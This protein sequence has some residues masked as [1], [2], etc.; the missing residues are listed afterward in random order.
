[1]LTENVTGYKNHLAKVLARRPYN[2]IALVQTLNNA[3][4]INQAKVLGDLTSKLGAI[5]KCLMFYR[6]A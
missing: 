4:S 5:E 2:I 3:Q 6:H 1:M